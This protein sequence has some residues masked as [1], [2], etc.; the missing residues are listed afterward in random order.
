MFKSKK[1]ITFLRILIG[2][3]VFSLFQRMMRSVTPVLVAM[4]LSLF[5]VLPE[6]AVA[7]H[8][9]DHRYTVSGYVRDAEG[10]PLKG[11][12]VLLEHK[13]GQK[14]KVATNPFG[15]YEAL[16]HLHDD[17][18]GDQITVTAGSEVKSITLSFTPG[19]HATPRHGEVDFGA[20]GKTSP[21]AWIYWT[22]G[23]GFLV[24]VILCF[25]Y[26]RLRGKKKKKRESPRKPRK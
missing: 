11:V 19:D 14:Y 2:G 23:F 26:F 9:A 17:N 8:E 24:G 18:L 4:I 22:G 10:N 3:Q 20:P 5:F 21:Y 6:V 13:G 12:D 1:D 16:F 15:Y 25:R 7:T